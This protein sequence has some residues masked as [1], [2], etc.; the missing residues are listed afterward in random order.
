MSEWLP[1]VWTTKRQSS[2]RG[3]DVVIRYEHIKWAYQQPPSQHD[4]LSFP[5]DSD[6]FSSSFRHNQA[7]RTRFEYLCDETMNG[8]GLHLTT[9]HRN[10][11]V[12]D[13]S[14]GC[15]RDIVQVLAQKGWRKVSHRKRSKLEKKRLPSKDVPFFIWTINE[16]DLDFG[17]VDAQTLQVCNHY[18]GITNTLTSKQGFCDLLRDMQWSCDD[19]S[20]MSPRSFNLGDAVQRE[21]FID[22]FKMTAAILILKWALRFEVSNARNKQYSS[23]GASSSGAGGSSSS[24]GVPSDVKNNVRGM[25][26]DPSIDHETDLSTHPID[27]VLVQRAYQACV[28]YIRLR[29]TGEC[30]ELEDP[31]SGDGS[32]MKDKDKDGSTKVKRKRVTSSL[33]THPSDSHLSSNTLLSN[34]LTTTTTS[35]QHHPPEAAAY[36][37][38]QLPTSSFSLSEPEWDDLLAYSYSLAEIESRSVRPTSNTVLWNLLS[39]KH[40]RNYNNMATKLVLLLRDV[41][42]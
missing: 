13:T 19:A 11:S 9:I 38:I 10:Y 26:H 41:V 22:D 36:T 2:R 32:S 39:M 14:D 40:Y 18:E 3:R 35:S 15:Y 29:S 6:T 5:D 23:I 17:D 27:H 21:E 33:S 42:R 7:A 25:N 20:E 1:Q 8:D 16:K 31:N 30:P 28:F 24:S 12:E 34:P 4:S 37:E